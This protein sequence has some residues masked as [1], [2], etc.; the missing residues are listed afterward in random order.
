MRVFFHTQLIIHCLVFKAFILA[1]IVY[2]HLHNRFRA[3]PLLNLL[4]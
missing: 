2:R 4:M 3:L 1:L